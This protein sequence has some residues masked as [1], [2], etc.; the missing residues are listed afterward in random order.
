MLGH[1]LIQECHPTHH[2]LRFR[3]RGSTQSHSIVRSAEENV[4]PRSLALCINMRCPAIG[5]LSPARFEGHTPITSPS[6][7]SSM[8]RCRITA[9]VAD[10]H[11]GTNPPLRPVF[12]SLGRELGGNPDAVS[13]L[14]RECRGLLEGDD[15]GV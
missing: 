8:S 13:G 12:W 14:R 3:Y 2:G 1:L 4:E 5:F 11:P 9:S 15:P 7:S 10:P 6:G